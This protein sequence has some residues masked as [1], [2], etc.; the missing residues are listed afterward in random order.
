MSVAQFPAA[1]QCA[2]RSQF[3]CSTQFQF[4]QQQNAKPDKVGVKKRSEIRIIPPQFTV[5]VH[6]L[7]AYDVPTMGT[8]ARSGPSKFV[9]LTRIR[10]LRQPDIILIFRIF[11]IVHSQ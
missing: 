4:E 7:L 3:F 11:Q 5:A 1:E 9:V 10:G 6:E 2:V 8:H